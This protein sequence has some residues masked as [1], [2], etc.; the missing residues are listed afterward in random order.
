MTTCLDC[1][2]DTL[3]P[4][5]GVPTEY[6]QVHNGVWQAADAPRHAFLCVGCL[7]SRLGR[8]LRRADFTDAPINDLSISRTARFA[9][10]WRSDRLID[11]LSVPLS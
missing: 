2:T 5:P 11:R 3:S 8:R 1:G 9:W 7:E 10:S 4:E 6:Y